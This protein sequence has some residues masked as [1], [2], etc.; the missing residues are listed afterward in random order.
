MSLVVSFL[1][2]LPVGI[3]CGLAIVMLG[4]TNVAWFLFFRAHLRS[5]AHERKNFVLLSEAHV[6]K[7]I[8]AA[9]DERKEL[10]DRIQAKSYTEYSEAKALEEAA[11]KVTPTTQDRIDEIVRRENEKIEKVFKANNDVMIRNRKTGM[12]S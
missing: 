9:E 3:L 8:G 12:P 2:V 11:R 7:L 5:D 6:R 10:Y 4:I 1:G